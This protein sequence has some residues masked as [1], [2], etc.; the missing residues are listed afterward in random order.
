LWPRRVSGSGTSTPSPAGIEQHDPGEDVRLVIEQTG[1]WIRNADTKTGLLAT[2]VSVLVAAGA[3]K[4]QHTEITTWSHSATGILALAA[5][6][7]FLF[8][9]AIAASHML[10]VL[11][12]RTTVATDPS[13]FSWPWIS[14]RSQIEIDSQ[15]AS[16]TARREAW[17]QAKTLA[18]IAKVKHHYFKRAVAWSA[19]SAGFFLTWLVAVSFIQA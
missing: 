19:V 12:P 16:V 11:L 1:E 17:I 7:A 3:S 6:G 14:G 4:M 8:A 9:V 10:A 18:D 13:R 15:V 2:A 5:G